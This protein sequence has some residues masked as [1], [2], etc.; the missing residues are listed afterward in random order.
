MAIP[1]L[2]IQI[3]WANKGSFGGAYD[4]VLALMGPEDPGLATSRGASADRSSDLAGE[5]T[6]DLD[7]PNHRYTLDRNW[8]DNPSFEN[9]LDGW[10]TDAVPSLLA[11]ATSIT[12]VTDNSGQGGT[13]AMEIVLPATNNAGAHFRL[14]YPVKASRTYSGFFWAKSMSGTLSIRT[15]GASRGTPTDIASSTTNITTAWARYPWTWTPSADHDDPVIFVRSTTASAATLRIDTGGFNPGATAYDYIEAPTKG[16][17]LPGAPIRFYVTRSAVD[18]ARFFGRI[19]RISPDPNRQVVHVTCRDPLQAM[20]ETDVVIPADLHATVTAREVYLAILED[21]ARGNRNLLSNPSFETDTSG[22]GVSGGTLT[23]ITTDHAP[24]AGGSAC[25]EF[26]ASGAGQSVTHIARMSADFR[27]GVYHGSA[28]LRSPAGPTTWTLEMGFDTVDVDLTTQWTRFDLTQELT[29]SQTAVTG[30][31]QLRLVSQAA[32]T[33]RID[34]VA[35]TRGITLWPYSDTGSGR[36]PNWLSN[37]SVEGSKAGWKAAF[38]NLISNPSFE[39]NTAGWSVAGDAFVSAGTSITRNVSNPVYGTA[40]ATIVGGNAYIP[41]G[42]TQKS[43]QKYAW[44]L[45]VRTV[46]G[47]GN[48]FAGAGS[49]GTPTD[50]SKTTVNLPNVTTTPQWITGIWTPGADRTDG[51][52]FVGSVSGY[53]LI[54]DAAYIFPLEANTPVPGYSN[55]GPGAGVGRPPTIIIPVSS[56]AVAGRR[57]LKVTTPALAGAGVIYDFYDDGAY[58]VAGK[59]YAFVVPMEGSSSTPYRVGIGVNKG[60]GTWDENS[61]TGT[62]TANTPTDVPL[63]WTPAADAAADT[64]FKLV[65]FIWQTDATARDIYIDGVRGIPGSAADDFEATWWD[66]S[67]VTDDSY[68]Q[69]TDLSGTALSTLQVLNA[70]GLWRLWI[71]PEMTDPYYSIVAE[72]RDTF[73]AK[74]PVLALTAD[75]GW[76]GL[77]LDRDAVI[78]NVRL[79]W[80]GGTS[81]RSAEVKRGPTKGVTIAGADWFTDRSIADEVATALLFRYSTPRLQ[82]T[83]VL[84]ASAE[85]ESM[86]DTILGLDLNDVVTKSNDA[87]LMKQQDFVI[88]RE[89]LRITEGGRKWVGSYPLEEF[90]Y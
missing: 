68:F 89:D 33:A 50:L 27:K 3:D 5:M 80:Q 28:F 40:S 56:H 53:D 22:W 65:L 77:D 4:T 16:E 39:T 66:I 84:Q 52:F 6:F 70:L 14:P 41:I 78:T 17:L 12:Q 34:G 86:F 51:H 29:A 44:G 58:F 11:A 69:L 31:V 24:E 49:N 79:E 30:S 21:F 1:T 48:A 43:G 67:H 45:A 32:D 85:N 47:T 7:N 55:T 87:F 64:P 73:A 9:G 63:T 72:D 71:R 15:G 18:K 76:S 60:D 19:Q 10:R 75:Q 59:Q 54:V 88:R 38:A 37:G 23:R 62:L 46:S 42:G 13:K 26:V 83:M 57:S 8:L 35:I 74:A 61:V 20:D 90:P 36:W 25:A 81:H 82:P 2:T